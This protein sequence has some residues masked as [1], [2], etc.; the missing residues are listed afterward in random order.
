L[1]WCSAGAKGFKGSKKGTPFAAQ[2][3]AEEVA[4]VDPEVEVA[5][6]EAHMHEAEPMSAV[7]GEVMDSGVVATPVDGETVTEAEAQEHAE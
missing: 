7:Q 4:P 6:A 3:A 5:I 2:V 1:A